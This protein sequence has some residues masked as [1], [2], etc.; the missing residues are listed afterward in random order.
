MAPGARGYALLA[1]IIVFTVLCL[2]V[3]TLRAWAAVVAK[4]KF[5]ADDAFVVFA[6]VSPNTRFHRL[7]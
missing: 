7:Q 6:F 4:R 5:Y 1:W 2:A 3:L